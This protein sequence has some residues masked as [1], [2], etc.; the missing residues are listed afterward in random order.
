MN[1]Q[2][3]SSAT[4]RVASQDLGTGLPYGYERRFI[5]RKRVTCAHAVRVHG[6]TGAMLA[7]VCGTTPGWSTHDWRGTGSQYEY[8]KALRLRLCKKCAQLLGIDVEEC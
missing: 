4:S 2:T 5:P 3:P 7:A 1:P 8:D 6:Y